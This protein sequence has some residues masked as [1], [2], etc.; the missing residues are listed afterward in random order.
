MTPS[1]PVLLCHPVEDGARRGTDRRIPVSHA[2]VPA[3]ELGAYAVRHRRLGELDE[4]EMDAEVGVTRAQHGN[5]LQRPVGSFA[6]SHGASDWRVREAMVSAGYPC[7]RGGE[8]RALPRSDD[9]F[10]IARWMVTW[11][12]PVSRIAQVLACEILDSTWPHERLRTRAD[13]TVRRRR[14]GRLLGWGAWA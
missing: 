10:A 5:V 1:M 11:G 2:S 6:N 3:D 8:E 13:R 9:P 12:T 4:R 7:R 14:L